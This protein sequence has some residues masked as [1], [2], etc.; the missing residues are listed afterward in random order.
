MATKVDRYRNMHRAAKEL[1]D[2]IGAPEGAVS[3]SV[4]ADQAGRHFRVI[5]KP[6]LRMLIDSVPARF[7]GHRVVLEWLEAR[8]A[9]HSLDASPPPGLN[10]GA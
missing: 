5:V 4:F 1:R 6:E 2:L 10:L 7:A 8:R 3:V 9:P